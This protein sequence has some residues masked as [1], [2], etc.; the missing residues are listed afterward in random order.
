LGTV[1]VLAAFT[2]AFA[3]PTAQDFDTPGTPFVGQNF[4]TPLSGP[5][6]AVTGPDSFSDGRFIRVQPRTSRRTINTVGFDQTETGLFNRIVADFDFRITCSGARL[7]FSGGGCADGFSLVLLDTSIHGTDGAPRMEKSLPEHGGVNSDL[8]GQFGFGFNTFNN[9]GFPPDVNSSN[10]LSLIWQNFQIPGSFINLNPLGFDLA[11]GTF[12]NHGPFHHAHIELVL[13]PDS[14]HVTMILTSGVTGNEIMPFANF[15]L[16][17]VVGGPDSL[18]VAPF[19]SRVGFGVRCGDACADYDLDNIVVQYLDP[20]GPVVDNQPPV[21]EAGPDQTIDCASPAGASV[22]LDGSLSSD[23][24]GDPLTFTWSGPFAE[25]GGTVNGA[26]PTVTLPPGVHTITL[27]VM[28]AFGETDV[29]EVVVRVEED[30]TQPSIDAISASPDNLW[31][32]NHKMVDVA[33]SV[34]VSDLCD[35]AISSAQCEIVAVTSNEPVNGAGD[36]DTDPDWMITGALTLQLRAER[37]GGG[38]GRL[39]TVTVACTDAAGNVAT[40]TTTVTV[41]KSQ[42]KK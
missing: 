16:S 37:S 31:P 28:D 33:V 24:D 25:G 15:D 30:A 10:S 18:P 6:P 11:T 35:T 42:G 21:A 20:V 32:A 3:L 5:P 12:G 17:A 38:S 8:L 4:P 40:A 13:G 22:M 23:P 29:D 39:Y 14:P 26:M 36:G 41:P 7:G 1:A 19:E 34:D 9:F 2:A 27:T